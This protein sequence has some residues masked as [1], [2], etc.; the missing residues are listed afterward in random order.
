MDKGV[1]GLVRVDVDIRVVAM[2]ERYRDF[3]ATGLS[4]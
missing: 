3:Q 2:G 1:P 4:L